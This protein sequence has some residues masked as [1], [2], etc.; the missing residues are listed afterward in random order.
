M[1]FYNDPFPL[2][3]IATTFDA[4]MIGIR[5]RTQ[6]CAGGFISEATGT[7]GLGEFYLTLSMDADGYIKG[8]KV[9]KHHPTFWSWYL[10][11]TPFGLYGIWATERQGIN[12]IGMLGGA[13][14]LWKREW[15]E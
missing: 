12:D 5:F 9:Y 7:D 14:W 6:G 11:N 10:S 4:P 15:C 3:A 1:Y 2:N 13:V 8:K